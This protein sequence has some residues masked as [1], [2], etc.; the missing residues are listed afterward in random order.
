MKSQ[1]EELQYEEKMDQVSVQIEELILDALI[2]ALEKIK[3]RNHRFS[4]L[5]ACS[6]QFPF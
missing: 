2:A 1:E 5:D 3:E 6:E 4:K